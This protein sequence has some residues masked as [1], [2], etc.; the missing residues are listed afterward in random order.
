MMIGLIGYGLYVTQ[1]CDLFVTYFNLDIILDFNQILTCNWIFICNQIL[2]S[3]QIAINS[4][5]TY[6]VWLYEAIEA[7]V[8]QCQSLPVIC[9]QLES[10]W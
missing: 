5:L 1:L 10:W 9:L 8:L 4:I 7:S 3:I 2:A 6:F